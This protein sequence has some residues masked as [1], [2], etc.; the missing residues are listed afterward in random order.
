MERLNLNVPAETRAKLR[1]LAARAERR[2]AEFARELLV[3]AVDEAERRAIR[4][5]FRTAMSPALRKRLREISHSMEK[6]RGGAG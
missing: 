4:E 2:E 3:Q 1:R 5:R 6:L